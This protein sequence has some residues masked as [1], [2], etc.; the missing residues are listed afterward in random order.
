MI[1]NCYTFNN[2][3]TKYSIGDG[4]NSPLFQDGWLKWNEEVWGVKAERVKY[5]INGKEQPSLEGVIYTDKK[6]RV[7]LPPRNPYLPFILKTT[8]TEKNYK[9][10]QQYVNI[11]SLFADDLLKRGVRGQIFLPVGFLDARPFQWRGFNASIRYTFVNDLPFKF[12]LAADSVL[13][14]KKKSEKLGYTVS[15]TED[16]G[17]IL[18][19]LNGTEKRKNFEHLL[20]IKSLE[21]C[22]KLM[23][24]EKFIGCLCNDK[25]GEP[26]S[27]GIR[28]MQNEGIAMGCVQGSITSH[29]SNGINQLIYSYVLEDLYKRGAKRFDWCGANISSV[30]QAKS[31]WG[32]VLTPYLAIEEQNIWAISRKAIS[33]VVKKIIE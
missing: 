24:S 31:Q 21:L 15:N 30:A 6:G 14:Q 28:L 11:V 32:M 27:G 4:L 9:I 3:N 20:D 12:D 16:W 17:K 25:N 22:K 1:T 13:K 33:H 5:I 29:L 18:F 10:Y 23:G 19:C 2:L 26:V 8:E 7:I